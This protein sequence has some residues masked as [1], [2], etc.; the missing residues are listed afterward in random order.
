MLLANPLDAF[1]LRAHELVKETDPE[2]ARLLFA[3]NGMYGAA[4]QVR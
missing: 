3:N 1:T 4:Q 2:R